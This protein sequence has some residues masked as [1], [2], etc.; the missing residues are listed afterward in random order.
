MCV[1]MYIHIGID[2]GVG[3]PLNYLHNVCI[4]I[5][6]TSTPPNGE[7]RGPM[8]NELANWHYMVAGRDQGFRNM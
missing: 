1:C 5:R 3:S 8:Q 4:H 2:I 7:S 6:K